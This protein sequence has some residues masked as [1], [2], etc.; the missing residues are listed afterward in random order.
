MSTLTELEAWTNGTPTGGPNGDGRYPLTYADGL[1]Y[2]VYCP[3]AQALNPL[4]AEQ[5]VEVFSDQ[6]EAAAAS[7]TTA[8]SQADASRIAAAASAANAAQSATQALNSKTA[9]AT[10]ETNANTAKT[11]AQTAQT[12]AETAK[13]A[14][15]NWASAPVN[16]VVS[17][18]LYSALHYAN[19]AATSASNA[20]ASAASFNSG[21]YVL[22]SNFTWANLGGKPT[23]W[24][25]T[26]VTEDST[27]RFV[28]DTEKS[29]WNG[30]QAALGYTPVNKAGD[31][32]LGTMDWAASTKIRGDFSNA[33]WAN[34]TLVQTTTSNGNS[35]AG[36]IPNGTAT[37]SAWAAL[38]SS[39]ASNAGMF[40]FRMDAT[41]AVLNS[42]KTGTGATRPMSFQFD[43]VEK[44]SLSTGGDLGISGAFTSTGVI[45]ATGGIN[46]ASFL[47]SVGG[48]KNIRLYDDNNSSINLEIGAGYASSADGNAYIANRF[49][50]AGQGFISI[51]AKNGAHRL[52]TGDDTL[53]ISY[54]DQQIYHAGLWSV[55]QAAESAASVVRRTAAGYVYANYFNTPAGQ[56][57]LSISSMYFETAN[58][59]FIRKMSPTQFANQGKGW[60]AFAGRKTAAELQVNDGTL[61][62]GIYTNNGGGLL[63]AAGTANWLNNWYHVIH[64]RHIDNN[65]F[66]AQIALEL[67]DGTNNAIF[68]RGSSGTTWREWSRVMV[69]L[70][71]SNDFNSLGAIAGSTR[72]FAKDGTQTWNPG[73]KTIQ[74]IY[75]SA[76]YGDKGIF[77]V[78]DYSLGYRDLRVEA[79][80]ITN[81]LNGVTGSGSY[82]DGNGLYLYSGWL[83][84]HGQNGFYCQ[85]YTGGWYMTD[86]TYMRSYN[87]K[88][89]VAPDF[90]A[91]SDARLKTKIRKHKFR[92][93]LA[94]KDFVW[95]ESGEADFGFIAQDVQKLYPEAVGRVTNDKNPDDTFLVVSYPKLVAAL[96]AQVNLLEDRLAKLEARCGAPDQR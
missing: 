59:G 6:A 86:T 92:G 42:T 10:S 27:H 9:A 71:G 18:G 3:A 26:A 14:A 16:T 49:T 7:A 44:M 65:G 41:L 73:G 50:G 77:A 34:R 75:N 64:C 84:T 2:L 53:G 5:P 58:D 90:V 91:T 47:K 62:P 57:D 43:G 30:K 56:Q 45:T 25:A 83:R 78:Y 15:Q 81:A 67:S 88:A 40:Q 51:Y 13:T 69:S 93:R 28:T 8:A 19:A 20:A 89:V 72:V 1:T 37:T 23:T 87:S 60:N 24:A 66:S 11:A 70:P 4:A 12:A 95:K 29:A 54:N 94:P 17:G 85:D 96:W 31:T 35:V 80:S 76:L 55:S 46:F 39:D 82:Q 52:K 22:T 21:N 63:N 38:N 74:M 48:G 36:I 61:A 79:A 32:S 68:T 33:T